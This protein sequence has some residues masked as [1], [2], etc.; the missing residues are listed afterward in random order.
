MHKTINHPSVSV[1]SSYSAAVEVTAPTR[2]LFISGQVGRDADRNI[3][4]GIE[5]QAQIAWRN[6]VT[7]LTEGSMTLDDIVETTLYLVRREDNAGYD[8]VRAKW[9]GERRPAS[10][11]I[12]V[13]G[14][15]D[16]RMLCEIQAI[17]AK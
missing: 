12:Y 17:A 7:I 10:T 5:E 11:K 9:M 15:S 4:E 2:W 13:A 14:L 3:P 1:S 16:P 6:L 8:R